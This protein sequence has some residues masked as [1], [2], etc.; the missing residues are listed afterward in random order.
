ME[1]AR[2]LAETIARVQIPLMRGKVANKASA[3]LGV[4]RSDFERLLTKPSRERFSTDDEPRPA[5]TAPPR[6]EIGML[7]L[8][9]LR[10]EE[11]RAYL[12]AQDWRGMLSHTPDAE[13]L[14]RILGGGLRPNDPVS[15]NAFMSGLPAGEEALVS[16]WLLQ[17]MPPNGLEVAQGFWNGLR[18][19]TLRRQL[20]I[21]EGRMKL[22]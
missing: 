3:R 16:S 4:P 21:A 15:L 7:C 11:A 18:Q 1:L 19:A 5:V 2:R 17:K 13:I 22:L 20:Q 8:L 14:G 9:A 12:L 10:H 6:H